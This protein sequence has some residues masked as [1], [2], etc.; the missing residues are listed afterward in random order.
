MLSIYFSILV[1]LLVAA[2]FFAVCYVLVCGSPLKS[3]VS[4]PKRKKKAER[5]RH[6]ARKETP[7]EEPPQP[8]VQESAAEA[9]RVFL[10]SETPSRPA[11]EEATRIFGREELAEKESAPAAG[12]KSGPFALEKEPDILEGKPDPA[13]LEEYFVR[14]FLAQYG[15]VSRTIAEDTRTVTHEL[16]RRVT[17]VAGADAA[18]I[19]THIMVQEALQNAQRTYAMLPNETVLGMVGDAFCDVAKGSKTETRTILAYD[20]LKAM[21]RMEMGQFRA[22]AL[23]LLFHYSRNIENVD[24]ASFKAYAGKY[25]EP[26]MQGLPSEYSGYQQLEYLHCISLENK[27]TPFGQVLRDSYP[28]VFAYR[29][30]MKTELEGIQAEWPAGAIVPSLY[31]SYFKAAVM[32]ESM[33][34]DYFETYGITDA[35]EQTLLD[36]LLHSRPV[37][38]DRREMAH[39]LGRISGSLERLQDIWDN[40]LLRRSSLTLMGMYMAQ[41]Y[42]RETV[43]EE[44]DLSHWI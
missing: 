11:E 15:A 28:L 22:L 1:V 19:L 32:D 30:C 8:A 17:G 13:Q 44:F 18:D 24:A 12:V 16:I 38:Y 43:G 23:L 6:A 21:P 35:R 5:P 29:G 9:T 37:A 14:H 3:G 31:N 4:L 33:L 27:D 2:A 41:I 40:S 7:K 34:P 39:L 20:A 36:A 25:V 10:R 26:M 42:I